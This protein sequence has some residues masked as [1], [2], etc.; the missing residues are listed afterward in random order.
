MVLVGL[1]SFGK[2]KKRKENKARKER[3]IISIGLIIT[4]NV[5]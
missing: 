2:E 4:N 5:T 1:R 3:V